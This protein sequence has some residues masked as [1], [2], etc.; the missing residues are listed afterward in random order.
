MN[1]KRLTC[2]HIRA[3]STYHGKQG[4]SYL[5]G[6]SKETVGAQAICMHVLTMPPGAHAKPHLHEHH[7]TAIYVLS[8]Q[9]D[10]WYGHQ[11]EHHVAANAGDLFYI[12]AG[13]PHMPANLTDAPA[14]AIV[15]RTDPN[16]QESVV[17]LPQL[18]AFV[19]SWTATE[20]RS[21]CG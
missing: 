18:E 15:A 5:H 1:E 13:M 14:S 10:A 11:L 4:L 9:I 12:P 8:G 6:I 20:M 17:L 3:G 21:G 7:E 19:A 2:Q 16:E